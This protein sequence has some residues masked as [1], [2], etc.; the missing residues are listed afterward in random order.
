MIGITDNHIRRMKKQSGYGERND[1][2]GPCSAGPSHAGRCKNNGCV[3]NCV[4]AREEP[5]S[6]DIC[7]PRAMRQLR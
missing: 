4:I 3:A 1:Q 6:P 5:N 2:I 7:I